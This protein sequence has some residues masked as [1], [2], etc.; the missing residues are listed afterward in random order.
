MSAN[1]I[2]STS[3][4]RSSSTLAASWYIAL[5]SAK[6]KRKPLAVRLFGRQLVAWRDYDGRPVLMARQCPHMGA[7]LSDGDVIGGLLRCPFHH[8][9]FDGTGA[10]A[11]IPG[12][13]RIPATATLRCYPAI[14]RAGYVWAWYGSAEPMF[15][16]P[17][18]PAFSKRFLGFRLA[19]VTGA[20][21]RRI[22]ENT[23]DPDHL[24]ALHGLEVGGPLGFRMLSDQDE[25][26]H[27]GAPID[28]GAWLG[29]EL[30]WPGYVGWLGTITRFLGTN[31]ERFSL[32]VD[33]WPTGQRVSYFADGVL[34]YRLLLSA[35]PIGPNRTVQ[36]IAVTAA[37]TGR[38]LSDLRR[39]LANRL[40]ITFASN[41]DLPIFNTIEPGDRHGIYLDRDRAV[42]RYRK[43][44]QGWVD[45]V[46]DDA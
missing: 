10:C 17:E 37:R 23:F 6:L 40:E 18:L 28:P 16:L 22:M 29:A 30:T 31:A 46:A 8:W 41:Q 36:H 3:Y 7:S 24:V 38:F 1:T 2:A 32:L 5:P 27:H 14:E 45:K 26:R 9:K 20:T 43:H 34:Q 11:E 12:V 42:L 33:S 4:T 15:P 19:D 21:V 39:Y 25:V 35:T 13:R 44:Y